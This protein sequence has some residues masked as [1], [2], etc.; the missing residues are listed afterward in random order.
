MNMT[1]RGIIAAGC[2]SIV[3]GLAPRSAWAKTEADVIVIGAGL[4]GLHA[5]SLLEAQ[6]ANVVI[7]EADRRIGGRLY[8]LDDVPGSPEAG[9][10]QIGSGYS[11]TLLLTKKHNITVSPAPVIDRSMLYHINGQSVTAADWPASPAN[12]LT[13]NE[14][15]LPPAALAPFYGTRLPALDSVDAWMGPGADRLDIP[16]STAL[17]QA[18][19]SRE[20]L[21]LINANLNG[22]SADTIS[23]LH[24]AR[25][26]AIFRASPG[27]PMMVTGGSQRL[28]EAMAAALKTP[29]RL[30]QA[31]I[32]L[33][34]EAG[35]VT[36]ALANGQSLTARHV[37]CTVPF[38]VLRY[39]H[40]D[41]PV[42][43]ALSKTI[44]QLPYTRA[45]F[46]YLSASEPFW[47]HDGLPE[48]IWSD[49]PL[50]GRVFVLGDE[51]A[52][53]KVWIAGPHTPQIDSM[54]SAAAAE[55]IIERIHA[56]RPSSRGKLKLERL[57]SWQKNPL[58]RGIYHHIA[59]GQAR[60]LAAASRAAGK[61]LHYAGEHLAQRSSGIEAALESGEHSA[62]AILRAL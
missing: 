35:S 22:N 6:G 24:I 34:E 41:A 45:S 11:R 49:H 18:G 51:P 2:A 7:L 5:A 3:A 37:I 21:R 26:S 50:L 39:L 15:A 33:R 55:A 58:A 48:T 25:T 23:A 40:I 32:G 54:G 8:T 17:S 1:R 12:R 27:Q 52:M 4:A 42:A 59:P 62:G 16:Y 28:P 30:G 31:V 60:L 29:P 47:R 43:P 53:L 14:H 56:A 38:S 13:G 44:D 19:A 57:F 61:R 20:A 10:V 46:A 36:V 9:G